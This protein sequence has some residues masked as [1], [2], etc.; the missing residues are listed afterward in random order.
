MLVSIL[1]SYVLNDYALFNI[2]HLFIFYVSSHPQY[3]FGLFAMMLMLSG[4]LFFYA[5]RVYEV[6]A[7]DLDR[8]VIIAAFIFLA[9]SIGATQL[10]AWKADSNYILVFGIWV[11]VLMVSTT[12]LYTQW[13]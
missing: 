12:F 3:Q 6:E 4:S 13:R 10:L 7:F 8:R 5:L 1:F 11:P 2:L 9:I